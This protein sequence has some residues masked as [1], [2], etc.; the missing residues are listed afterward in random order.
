MARSRLSLPGSQ[1]QTEK[2]SEEELG[3]AMSAGSESRQKLCWSATGGQPRKCLSYSRGRPRRYQRRSSVPGSNESLDHDAPREQRRA[4]FMYGLHQKMSQVSTRRQSSHRR[5]QE[6]NSKEEC[7]KGSRGCRITHET[8]TRG[9]RLWSF[10]RT[11]T[12]KTKD[13]DSEATG[14]SRSLPTQH[15]SKVSE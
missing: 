7:G 5:T 9:G 15:R 14:H 11:G 10:T 3:G 4:R 1:R 12:K 13:A 8:T 6:E 2:G